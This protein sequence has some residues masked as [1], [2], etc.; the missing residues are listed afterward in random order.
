MLK[1]IRNNA[2]RQQV[3]RGDSIPA[4]VGGWDAVSAVADMPEDRALVL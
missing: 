3:S 4:P 1:P 2:S